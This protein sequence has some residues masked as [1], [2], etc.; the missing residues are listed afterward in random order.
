MLDWQEL[1]GGEKVDIALIYGGAITLGVGSLL[2]RVQS[3]RPD[4]GFD[5]WLFR[6]QYALM[7]VFVAVL[8]LL[9]WRVRTDGGVFM[10]N[11]LLVASTVGMMLPPWGTELI[12]VGSFLTLGAVVFLGGLGYYRIKRPTNVPAIV[13]TGLG[14]LEFYLF[15]VVYLIGSLF[16]TGNLSLGV[17]FVVLTAIFYGFLRILSREYENSYGSQLDPI[18]ESTLGN[19]NDGN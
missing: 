18:V 14:A 11:G 3:G 10:T 2:L 12:D 1:D 4:A 7:F 19:F 15:G 9:R 17:G 5:P 13:I 16:E 8:G 6:T